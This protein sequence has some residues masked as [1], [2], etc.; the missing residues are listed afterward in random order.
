MA[1]MRSE[2]QA[3]FRKKIKDGASSAKKERLAHTH[4]R[5]KGTGGVGT[6]IG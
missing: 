3:I 4:F 5:N 1:A 6:T 2:S